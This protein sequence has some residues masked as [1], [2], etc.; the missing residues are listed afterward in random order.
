M[1]E[2]VHS[3][4]CGEEQKRGPLSMA[5]PPAPLALGLSTS[6]RLGAPGSP[7]VLAAQAGFAEDLRQRCHIR[8]EAV[9]G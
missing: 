9:V 8:S 7:A 3:A 2:P 4:G 1:R 5:P 6:P